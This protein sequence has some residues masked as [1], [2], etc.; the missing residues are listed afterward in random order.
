MPTPLR[1]PRVNNNDDVVKLRR[2]LV[3][4][5]DR[6]ECGETVAEIET[7]KASFTV[8]TEK[9][10]V[11]VSVQAEA[12]DAMPVG[13]VLLWIGATADD[14]VIE[15]QSEAAVR[16]QR[17]TPTI[18]ARRLLNRHGLNAGDVRASG[19]RLTAADVE[20]HVARLGL[21]EGHVV[22]SADNDDLGEGTFEGLSA[23]ERA[24]LR[25]VTW[26]R[27]VAVPAYAEIEFEGT[28]WTAAAADFQKREG[29][30]LNPLLGLM[31]HRLA[32]IATRFPRVNSTIVGE[33]RFLYA[34]V[35]LGFT[36]QAESVLYLTVLRGASRLG[37]R[38]FL[39]QLV[40]LER[41]AMK[42]QLRQDEVSGATIAF[43]SM[44]RWSVARHV[45]VLPPNTSIVIA[46]ASSQGSGRIRLG[47][48]Y[49]H[50]VLTGADAVQVLNSLSRPDA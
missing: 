31:A 48:T 40:G 32:T 45:P 35:N 16:D 39:D 10:G 36:V 18:K 46:H 37:R 17:A 6:V 33:R 49:D 38:E 14:V 50:R 13:A 20:A 43:S 22:E 9:A 8:E 24:M 2:L 47:A 44:A 3:K 30:L 28:E 23:H 5:G 15:P 19:S 41:R 21:S 26:Q 11:V 42:N 4:V 12:D 25:T 7:D 1:T 29:L 34:D 27:D